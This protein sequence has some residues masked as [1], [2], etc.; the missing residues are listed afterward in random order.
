VLCP[1]DP[2]VPSKPTQGAKWMHPKGITT[3]KGVTY[4]TSEAAL[5]VAKTA[6]YA[7]MSWASAAPGYAVPNADWNGELAGS[8]AVWCADCACWHKLA[9]G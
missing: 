5:K 8:Y 7:I 2:V 1:E 4:L 3:V 9:K 6:G